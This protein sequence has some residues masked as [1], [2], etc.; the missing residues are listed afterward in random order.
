MYNLKYI[1][2][3]GTGPKETIIKSQKNDGNKNYIEGSQSDSFLIIIS[4]T[5]AKTIMSQEIKRSNIT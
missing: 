2:K 5:R 1:W 3:T 4:A